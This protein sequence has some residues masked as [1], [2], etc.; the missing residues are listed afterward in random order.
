MKF[1]D[2][3]VEAQKELDAEFAAVAAKSK[4]LD[5][6]MSSVATREALV[7][8]KLGQIAAQEK[9]ARGVGEVRVAP[10]ERV[11]I[12]HDSRRQPPFAEHARQPFDQRPRR[13]IHRRRGGRRRRFR[14]FRRDDGQRCDRRC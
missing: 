11:P 4:K 9:A 5:E 2:L 1:T 12:F 8:S 3:A 6:K 14:R 13:L 10:L 7:E